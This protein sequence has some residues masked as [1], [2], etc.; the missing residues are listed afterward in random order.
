M[1]ALSEPSPQATSSHPF[2]G[3]HSTTKGFIR[4]DRGPHDAKI[5]IGG[6]QLLPGKSGPR[7][8]LDRAARKTNEAARGISRD[9]GLD[10]KAQKAKKNAPSSGDVRQARQQAD[11]FKGLVEEEFNDAEDTADAQ[12]RAE[13]GDDGWKS[14]VFD[15]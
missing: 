13:E 9:L 8:S 4:D 10:A 14:S 7:S 11:Q 15:F 3:L 12:R 1:K 6:E 2:S 5:A